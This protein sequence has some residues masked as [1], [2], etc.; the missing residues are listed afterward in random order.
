MVS[1]CEQ[2]RAAARNRRAL[3]SAHKAACK[4]SQPRLWSICIPGLSCCPYPDRVLALPRF[5]LFHLHLGLEQLQLAGEEFLGQLR[6]PFR[7]PEIQPEK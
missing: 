4:R 7:L 3:G 5:F 6:L 1:S 2:L